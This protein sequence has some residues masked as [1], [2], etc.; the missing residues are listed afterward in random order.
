VWSWK[1]FQRQRVARSE[2][3]SEY[4]LIYFSGRDGLPALRGPLGIATSVNVTMADGRVQ[5][6][7]WTYKMESGT[8]AKTAILED[9]GYLIRTNPATLVA[10]KS[11]RGDPLAIIQ[12][13]N[14]SETEVTLSA[15]RP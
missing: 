5:L 7:T 14:S 1:D 9:N 4:S 15:A 8:R 11:T 3:A 13:T 12:L 2:W 6:V 10:S